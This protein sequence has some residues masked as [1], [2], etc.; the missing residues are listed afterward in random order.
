MEDK[1]G[2]EQ[3]KGTDWP[4]NPNEGYSQVKGTDWPAEPVASKKP[5]IKWVVGIGIGIFVA[6][7]A[8]AY[9][10]F[11][12]WSPITFDDDKIIVRDRAGGA[13]EIDTKPELPAGFPSDVPIHPDATLRSTALLVESKD[14]EQ[15]GSVYLW[16]VA[17]PLE[18]VGFW[19][20]AALEQNGWETPVKNAAGNSVFLTAIKGDRGFLMTI[21]DVS[22]DLTEVA[23]SFSTEFEQ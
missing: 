11:Q 10:W 15:E 5:I 19:Y 16:G 17:G 23:L 8:V 18:D 7:V 21:T 13:M 6:A 2:F 22:G 14:P 12:Y 3:V 1:N 4:A 9:L 20:T